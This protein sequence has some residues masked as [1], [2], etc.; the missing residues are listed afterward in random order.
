M[1]IK[2][3]AHGRPRFEYRL[4]AGLKT[5][6]GVLLFFHVPS[7][8]L[9][10]SSL[11]RTSNTCRG[12]LNSLRHYDSTWLFLLFFI[13]LFSWFLQLSLCR[14][15]RIVHLISVSV[16]LF[17]L[18]FDDSFFLRIRIQCGSTVHDGFRSKYIRYR[19]R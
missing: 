15:R 9:P 7:R 8:F 17:S 1:V 4:S 19:W 18:F 11:P 5:I 16:S 2:T 14:K 3:R 6:P 12:L 10:R 13:S